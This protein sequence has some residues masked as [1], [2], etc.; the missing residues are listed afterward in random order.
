M[1]AGHGLPARLRRPVM[2]L[3]LPEEPEP[4]PAAS[5]L[6]IGL[7]GGSFNPAHDGHRYVSLNALRGLGLDQVW[8]L[9]SPQNPLKLVAGMAPFAERLE[10]AR[11]VAS[12][13]RIRVSDIEARLGTQFTVETV[14]RL[15]ILDGKRFVWL[16]GADNLVQLPRW[17]RWRD[18]MAAVPVAVFERAPY[19]YA[20]LAG[21]AAACFGMARIAES[22]LRELVS[23]SP[24]AWAFVRL[25]AHPASSTAIRRAAVEPRTA[26]GWEELT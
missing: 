16:L 22:G 18:I 21:K 10:R 5:P 23:M 4:E 14:E 20:A 26:S 12:H 13:P 17:R 11:E 19:S 9:V 6:R 1:I 3:A 24:P 25:R 2:R 8:W 7:L 15:R